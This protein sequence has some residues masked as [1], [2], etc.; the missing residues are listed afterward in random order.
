MNIP[1]D[2]RARFPLLLEL[3][4]GSESMSDEERQYWIRVLPVMTHEQ[5]ADLTAIL[6]NEK[7]QLQ[8]I[9]RKYA[10][11]IETVGQRER[12]R[13]TGEELRERRS[14]R[15]REEEAHGAHEEKQTEKILEQIE[16]EQHP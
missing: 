9:D 11:E 7:R 12:V 5:I 13:R 1:A 4:L 10:A 14:Q 2:T 15:Q 16:G 3:I 8:A 6:E